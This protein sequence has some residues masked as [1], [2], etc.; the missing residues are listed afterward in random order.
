ML[1]SIPSHKFLLDE[2]VKKAL[3]TFLLSKKF[4][5]AV[6]PKSATDS[7]IAT[8]SFKE[9]RI[10]VT[11]DED[12]QWYTRDQVYSVVLLKIPQSDSASLI[13]SF[14]KLLKEFSNFQ[15]RIVLLETNKWID[16]PLWEEVI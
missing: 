9:K 3:L 6:V 15:G 1:L 2:N 13:S 14:E 16:S 5:V 7:K 8:V 10:L 12:F 4:D 11:N